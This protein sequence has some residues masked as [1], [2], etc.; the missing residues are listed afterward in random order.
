MDFT[1]QRR[2]PTEKSTAG[3]MF[4][5]LAFGIQTPQP[6]VQ[7]T[8][9]CF[10]MEPPMRTDNVKPR[11]IPAGRY[12]LKW[13]YSLKHGCNVPHVENVPGF[14][15]VEIHIG[16]FG[17]EHVK[18]GKLCPPDTEACLLV[19]L[20]YAPQLPD[21][22]GQSKPA[23][24]GLYAIVEDCDYRDEEMWITYIDPPATTG[25]QQP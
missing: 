4:C 24:D 16:N 5:Q 21:F 17:A 23:R 9:H 25:R 20:S 1:V 10:T 15:E 12:P 2:W 18:F 3:E 6:I 7:S 14:T 22:I 8:F 11:A 13:R 19:G